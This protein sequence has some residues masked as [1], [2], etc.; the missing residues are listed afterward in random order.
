[1]LATT[2]AL[3]GISVVAASPV[4]G[5]HYVVDPPHVV[6]ADGVKS[7]VSTIGPGECAPTNNPATTVACLRASNDDT[8]GRCVSVAGSGAARVSYQYRPGTVYTVTGTGCLAGYEPPRNF[9]QS[10]GPVVARL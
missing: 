3:P 6:D 4:T 5:C 1:M 2:L 10:V 7:V 8:A 9:C